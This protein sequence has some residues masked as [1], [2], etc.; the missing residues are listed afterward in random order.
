MELTEMQ[1]E[2]VLMQLRGPREAT[3]AVSINI[4]DAKE[5]SIAKI[6]MVIAM[7]HVPAL[8]HP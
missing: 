4:Y 3:P 1:R 7:R 2:T 6:E 5:K 8:S